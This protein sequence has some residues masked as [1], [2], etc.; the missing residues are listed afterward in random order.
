MAF[1]QLGV[2]SPG[3][4]TDEE[5]A[6]SVGARVVN[7]AYPVGHVFRYGADPTGTTYSTQAFKDAISAASYFRSSGE[8]IVPKGDYKLAETLLIHDHVIIRGFVRAQNGP[9]A[10][11]NLIF[12]DDI[13]GIVC[14]NSGSTCDTDGTNQTT[15]TP[16]NWP[17]GSVR[18]GRGSMLIHLNCFRGDGSKPT[19]DGTSHGLRLRDNCITIGCRFQGFAGDGVHGLANCTGGAADIGN[20]NHW[21]LHDVDCLSNA[22]RGFFMD[23][24]CANAGAAYKCNAQSN[25]DWGIYDSS[26]L[27]NLWSGC[28]MA[29]NGDNVTVGGSALVDNANAKSVF[30]GCYAEPDQLPT[31]LNGRSMWVGG[32]NNDPPDGNGMLI[33]GEAIYGSFELRG[34][35]GAGSTQTTDFNMHPYDTADAFMNAQFPNV[36]GGVT[37]LTL[38]TGSNWENMILLAAHGNNHSLCRAFI[39]T[40]EST[41]Q[42]GRGEQVGGGEVW[43]QRFFFGANDEQARMWE[44]GT[45]APT[46]GAHAQGEIVWNRTPAAGGDVG[47]ICTTGGTP[48][49]WKTFGAIEA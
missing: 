44:Q 35:R 46:T 33:N 4:I 5:E 2:D 11:S 9:D 10:G 32:T 25:G 41:G 20:I 22:G 17:D 1:A 13:S 38:G 30:V 36:T 16:S 42:F 3:L 6:A 7:T 47:W 40:T 49:T 26:F 48:G 18:Q 21:E 27:G 43:F 37:F 24:D 19:A 45:A 29:T 31:N 8:V 12:D 23:G 34:R 15:R 14:H 39:C 28:H